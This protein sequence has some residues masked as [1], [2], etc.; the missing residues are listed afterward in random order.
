MTH[1]SWY[2]GAGHVVAHQTGTSTPSCTWYDS[3]GRVTKT[4]TTGADGTVSTA[5][6]SY[7]V[8]GDPRVSAVTATV[9]GQPDQ[10]TTTTTD[11]LGRTVRT[12]DGWGTTTSSSYDPDTGKPDTV[13]T[14]TGPDRRRGPVHDDHDLQLRHGRR[15]LPYRRVFAETG[16]KV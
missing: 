8:G 10:T 9:P 5:T 14:T 4:Q 7:A 12:V 6:T 2:D 11:L 13:T 15:H 16:V 3:A 1:T